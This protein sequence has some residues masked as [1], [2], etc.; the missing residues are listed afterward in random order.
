MDSVGNLSNREF[1]R[2][3]LL[4]N[5]SLDLA[6]PRQLRVVFAERAARTPSASYAGGGFDNLPLIR[7]IHS[8]SRQ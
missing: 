2:V 3:K 4:Q 7:P 5:S 6:T 8:E 1:V